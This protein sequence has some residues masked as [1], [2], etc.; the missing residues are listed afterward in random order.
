MG[1]I[2]SEILEISFF[3]VNAS[4]YKVQTTPQFPNFHNLR[5]QLLYYRKYTIKKIR[6]QLNIVHYDLLFAFCH[7]CILLQ[8][9]NYR[10]EFV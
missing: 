1:Q 9:V 5:E 7:T 10:K 4:S 3:L 2:S 6:Y 8:V